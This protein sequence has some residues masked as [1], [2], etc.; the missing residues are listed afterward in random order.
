MLQESVIRE[1]IL[2]ID[3][4]LESRLSLAKNAVNPRPMR[5]GI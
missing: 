2:W 1:I 3:K 4:N 5:A